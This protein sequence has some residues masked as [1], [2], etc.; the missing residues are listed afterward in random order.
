MRVVCHIARFSQAMFRSS[1]LKL[2]ISA[3]LSPRINYCKGSIDWQIVV[4][5]RSALWVA[6]CLWYVDVSSPFTDTTC[7]AS[8]EYYILVN[9]ILSL[10]LGYLV[11]YAFFF[12]GPGFEVLKNYRALGRALHFSVALSRAWLLMWKSP[13]SWFI[14]MH[15][16]KSTLKF[17][18]NSRFK[19]TR[20]LIYVCSRLTTP[21]STDVLLTYFTK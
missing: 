5:L 11:T 16:F 13:S 7:S 12:H 1:K 17:S 18:A 8:I 20:Q 6:L 15:L 4:F 19:T 2:L 9:V 3:V 10:Q 21:S 14:F